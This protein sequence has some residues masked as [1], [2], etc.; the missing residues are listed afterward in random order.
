MEL[1]K[2]QSPFELSLSYLAEHSL[3]QPLVQRVDH[4]TSLCS[5]YF[6]PSPRSDSLDRVNGTS[7]MSLGSF[8]L[9]D[10]KSQAMAT[11]DF[12]SNETS[13]DLSISPS[14]LF[15]S[16]QSVVAEI[17]STNADVSPTGIKFDHRCAAIFQNWLVD[18]WTDRIMM[19][20]R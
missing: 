9:S 18:F 16:F 3:A 6:V 7:F 5:P 8:F 11:S 19:N 17:R 4:L 14:L 2:I 12:V 20:A 1:G 10:Q 15:A 13:T